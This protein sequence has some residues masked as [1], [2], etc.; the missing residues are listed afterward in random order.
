MCNYRV[1]FG[2]CVVILPKYTTTE[3]TN[4]NNG[5]NEDRHILW[6]RKKNETSSE[7][8]MNEPKR[9]KM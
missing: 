4:Y 9:K 3:N 1:G 8:K 7:S 6:K 5:C 2:V